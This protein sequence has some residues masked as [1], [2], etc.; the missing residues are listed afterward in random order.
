MVSHL[1][2]AI[3][4]DMQGF[5]SSPHA[6]YEEL[7]MH[8]STT[9]P[10]GTLGIAGMLVSLYYSIMFTAGT[11]NGVEIVIGVVF[12]L[13]LDYAKIA[14]ANEAMLAMIQ[15][16]LLS[17]VLYSLIVISLYCL[18]MLAATFMLTSHS[19]NA[20]VA[21]S[22]LK[23]TTI[24]QAITAKRAELT[25][26]NPMVLTKCINPRTAELTALQADLAAAQNVPQDVLDAKNN[27]ATWEKM[28]EALGTQVEDLQVKLA[29]TRAILLEIIAPI[30]VSIFLTAYRNRSNAT[31]ALRNAL[32]DELVIN[33]PAKYSM[34]MDKLA[35]KA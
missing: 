17:A 31:V 21:Q 29:F 2:I 22:D 27:A 18:S 23:V 33:K 14:L 19:T 9:L 11:A 28:A 34:A 16:R 30:L 32:P 3:H 26:C 5:L 7:K 12:A 4:G 8:N 20:M 35:K 15:F 25:A 10:R 1:K 24:E 13:T 6:T